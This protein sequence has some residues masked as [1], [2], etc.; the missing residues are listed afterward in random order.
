MNPSEQEEI[1]AMRDRI[2]ELQNELW[3]LEQK[4]KTRLTSFQQV[5]AQE[6]HD[7]VEEPDHDYHRK[8]HYYTCRRCD[9]LTRQKE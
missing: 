2:Q 8:G 4:Y 7:F 9:Y 5:C 1:H 6:G 3:Q